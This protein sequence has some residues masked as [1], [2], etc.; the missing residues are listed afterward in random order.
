MVKNLPSTRADEPPPG[1]PSVIARPKPELTGVLSAPPIHSAREEEEPPVRPLPRAITSP[2]LE[3]ERREGKRRDKG[4]GCHSGG[5]TCG[6]HSTDP[7]R[8]QPPVF[9]QEGLTHS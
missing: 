5:V 2:T 9:P 6:L 8:T 4:G 7:A 3:R 1:P